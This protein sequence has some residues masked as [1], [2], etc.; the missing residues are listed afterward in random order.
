[1]WND[2][3]FE[4]ILHSTL[5]K[6]SLDW[7]HT[8]AC[9]RNFRG[10]RRCSPQS[11]DAAW[12]QHSSPAG[13]DWTF[14][15]PFS[16]M[17]LTSRLYVSGCGK[18]MVME[19]MLLQ[20]SKLAKPAGI[21]SSGVKVP[22]GNLIFVSGQVARNAAGETVGKGDIRAQTRQTLE[23][24]KAVLEAAGATMDD[25]VKVTVFVTD[26]SHLTAIH[27]VRAEYFK[28][29]YPASTLVEVKSLVSPE[30]MI[31][32]EAIAVTPA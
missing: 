15:G 3:L 21:F 5:S 11:Y 8:Q 24:V 26:V 14:E 30:L 16:I 7:A 27:E 20:S 2:A 12:Q 10:Q 22:V 32:I 13:K 4:A 23:N 6:S 31:E 29:D 19:K 25:I 1:M 17:Q 18:E 9:L 28:R